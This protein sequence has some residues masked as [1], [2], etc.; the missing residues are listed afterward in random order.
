[1][2]RKSF[3]VDGRRGFIKGA[4]AFALVAAA[5]PPAAACVQGV[6]AGDAAVAGRASRIEVAGRG[7]P[8]ARLVMRGVVYGADEKPAPG[9]KIF[10]YQ[11]DAEGF[12]SRP[13]S[14]PRRARL[15]GTV[16]T[17]AQGRYA[18]DTI[19]PGHYADTSQ[20]PPLHIHVHLEPPQLAEHWVESFYFE[21]DA[22]LQS[23]VVAR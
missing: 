19:K 14:D 8:G 9:V 6:P 12:Y 13:V 18:F 10:L 5:L 16:W 4:S 17:D 1:M 21:G 7:E 11:T 3:D 20:P 23:D 15:R 22:Q 2:A